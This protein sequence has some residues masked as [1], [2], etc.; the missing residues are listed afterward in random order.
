MGNE[1]RER[2][3]EE[4]E[5]VGKDEKMKKEWSGKRIERGAARKGE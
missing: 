2:R 3:K 4:Q 1:K 5:Y